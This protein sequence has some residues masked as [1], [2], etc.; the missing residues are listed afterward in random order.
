ML[1]FVALH[2]KTYVSVRN[3]ACRLMDTLKCA[4]TGFVMSH[5]ICN[6]RNCR[7]TF[8]KS[9]IA[10]CDVLIRQNVEILQQWAS[11][12][13]FFIDLETPIIIKIVAKIGVIFSSTNPVFFSRSQERYIIRSLSS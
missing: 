10:P 4:K 1:W 9:Y 8:G 13:F 6:V 7:L 3:L 11:G 12:N 5:F 2:F